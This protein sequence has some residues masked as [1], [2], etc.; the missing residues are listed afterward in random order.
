MPDEET[1]SNDLEQKMRKWRRLLDDVK[2]A[3]S[4][5]STHM[6]GYSNDDLRQYVAFTIKYSQFFTF[7][8]IITL[9]IA[10]F[11]FHCFSLLRS[12]FES[13]ITLWRICTNDINIAEQYISRAE[14]ATYN[15]SVKVN[16]NLKE[17]YNNYYHKSHL[18]AFKTKKGYWDR[19]LDEIVDMVDSAESEAWPYHRLMYQRLYSAGSEY[20]HPSSFSINESLAVKNVDDG[21]HAIMFKPKLG[22]EAAWW[23]SVIIIDSEKWYRRLIGEKTNLK[24]DDLKRAAMKLVSQS[25]KG[26]TER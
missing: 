24:L 6:K 1:Q 11:Y 12:L 4:N 2:N 26:K 8:S 25:M 15:I 14:I 17:S 22:M 18:A 23:A 13:H 20:L 10:G 9:F 19:P 3:I 5:H 7:D 16:I 21:H